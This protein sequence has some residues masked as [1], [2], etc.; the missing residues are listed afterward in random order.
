MTQ[1][2]DEEFIG[3]VDVWQLRQLRWPVMRILARHFVEELE[4]GRYMRRLLATGEWSAVRVQPR[5]NPAQAETH[6][7]DV[8]GVARRANQPVHRPGRRRRA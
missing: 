8:Y 3:T 6:V 4:L 2:V 7:Y 5:P 1:R